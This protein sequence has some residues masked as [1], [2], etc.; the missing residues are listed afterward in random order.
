MVLSVEQR[1]IHIFCIFPLSPSL[2]FSCVSFALTCSFLIFRFFSK[3]NIRSWFLARTSGIFPSFL[4]GE[5]CTSTWYH[6]HFVWV[7][8]RRRSVSIF[9]TWRTEQVTPKTMSSV[10]ST[11]QTQKPNIKSLKYTH[12]YTRFGLIRSFVDDTSC[13]NEHTKN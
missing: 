7:R 10:G 8:M 6:F 12:S 2:S 1:L 5:Q 13:N 4:G 9:K 3:C 11:C